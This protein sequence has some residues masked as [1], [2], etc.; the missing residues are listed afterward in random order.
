M[1][2]DAKKEMTN[3]TDVVREIE[4]AHAKVRCREDDYHHADCHDAL[5]DIALRQ[6]LLY[7]TA[8]EN[9]QIEHDENAR[10]K[11]K[12]RHKT[13][14]INILVPEN[15]RLKSE[16]ERLREMRPCSPGLTHRSDCEAASDEP[17]D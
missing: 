3:P 15:R 13:K 4:R 12:D 5:R 1:T 6:N 8:I 9:W 14:E 2:T 16:V 17:T 11:E 10:L 7:K